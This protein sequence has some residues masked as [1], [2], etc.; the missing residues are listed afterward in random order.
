[1]A[2]GDEPKLTSI[3]F[4]TSTS[5]SLDAPGAPTASNPR[6]P[7]AVLSVLAIVVGALAA[8]LWV[9]SRE[10][11]PADDIADTEAEDRAD[12]VVENVDPIDVSGIGSESSLDSALVPETLPVRLDEVEVLED[13]LVG[14]LSSGSFPLD[15]DP[16]L[17]SSDD[18]REWLDIE[19]SGLL[20]HPVVTENFQ[21]FELMTVGND[22][23]LLGYGPDTGIVLFESSNGT[24]WDLSAASQLVDDGGPFY[25]LGGINDV[26]VG[27]QGFTT[28]V[29]T[30][31]GDTEPTQLGGHFRIVSIDRDTGSTAVVATDSFRFEPYF[32]DE[33]IELSEGRIASIHFDPFG[34]V[35]R[36]CATNESPQP[37]VDA[38]AEFFIIDINANTVESWTLP[39][40]LERGEEPL[41]LGE[42]E[43]GSLRRLLFAWKGQ[44]WT[45]Q[46]ELEGGW[47]LIWL[48]ASGDGTSEPSSTYMVSES[49]TRLY[50]IDEGQLRIWDFVDSGGFL[51]VVDTVVLI[52][53]SQ[54]PPT[55]FS[56]AR[57]MYADDDSLIFATDT[58]PTWRIELP[59][60]LGSCERQLEQAGSST[61]DLQIRCLMRQ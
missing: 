17:V 5:T 19:P 61:D 30:C 13:Q 8:L 18:G 14:V 37:E 54:A 46:P 49:R 59:V 42:L 45:F 38:L 4:E 50:A 58:I 40:V 26:A 48:P 16:Y 23:G 32:V 55:D 28:G 56:E 31:P 6:R 53:P 10:S 57:I 11:E 20:E 34:E 7:W 2:A 1:M 15:D 21:L 35:D 29:I 12:P 60:E 33:A 39:V 22:I 52:E 36:P 47:N 51:D 41:F 44:L 24:D 43:I 25:V 9:N 27:F 3:E